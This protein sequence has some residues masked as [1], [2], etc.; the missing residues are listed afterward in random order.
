MATFWKCVA[1][2]SGNPP[3]PP[4]AARRTQYACVRRAAKIP[5]T[6]DKIDACAA[7]AVPFRP[8]CAGV[9]TRTQN[10]SE[11]MFVLALCLVLY[12]ATATAV[13]QSRVHDPVQ[14]IISCRFVSATKFRV[15]LCRPRSR[16]WRRHCPS[17]S[18]GQWSSGSMHHRGARASVDQVRISPPDSYVYH[19]SHRHIQHWARAPHPCCSA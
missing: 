18:T 12:S 10:V 13:V 5:L 19:D 2:P 6:G 8:Y 7:C 16:S 1:E 11:Y 15:V 14:C 4:H 9:A 3:G 17:S